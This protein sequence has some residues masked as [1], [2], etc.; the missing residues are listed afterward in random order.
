MSQLTTEVGNVTEGQS[1]SFDEYLERAWEIMISEPEAAVT[2]LKNA[3]TLVDPSDRMLSQLA[4]HEGWTFNF[5]GEYLQALKR[6][7][8]AQAL[9]EQ[10][11]SAEDTWR[12]HNGMG[13]AYQGM[14]QYGEALFHYGE[15]LAICQSIGEING[16]FAAQLNLATLHYDI[17][18][19]DTSEEL[20]N[21]ALGVDTTS[22]TA[23]NLGEAALLQ[24]NLHITHSRFQDALLGC[25]AALEY[26]RQLNFGHLEIQALIAVARCQRL[27]N[28]MVE[29]ETTLVVTIDHPEFD[30][31]GVTGLYAYIEL[32]K[33][34]ASNGHFSRA[35][36][37][38]RQGLRRE[39]L[40]EFSLIQQRA[41]ETLAV[42]LER[43]RKYRAAHTVLRLALDLE[44][45]LHQRDV[46]RQIE[47]RQYET[48]MKDERLARQ[49]AQHEN[50]Q[51][52]VVQSRLQLINELSRQLA[53]S[54]RI[55]DIGLKLYDIVKERL[56]VHF[57]S[58]ALNR[59]DVDAVEYV[60]A[61]DNGIRL[62]R[63]SIPYCFEQSPAVKAIRGAEPVLI[64]GND[65]RLC[66][67]RLGDERIVPQSQ[68][69][70]P[71][72]HNQIVIG[73]VSLQSAVPERFGDEEIELLRSLAPFIAIT[74]SN[75]LS[76]QQLYE[77]NSALSHEKTQIEAA[78][79][80]IE[81]MANH[82]T[83]T[84]LPNRRLL[85]NFV[86]QRVALATES[87]RSF[88]LVYI[89][90]DGF[91][92]VND[93][94]GHRVGDSVLTALANRLSDALRKTDFAARVGGDEFVI[95]IDDFENEPA[96]HAFISRMLSVIEKPVITDNEQVA[97]SA[98][99]GVA[100]YGTHGK[101]LDTLMHHAD[102]A[103]Y[104]IKRSGKGGIAYA[105]LQP[106]VLF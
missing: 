19:L 28:R 16:L 71:L 38:L 84:G 99:I 21:E 89:D 67:L 36:R 93:R 54:L 20:L 88:Y 14:G 26:S 32:A 106:R 55:E 1:I 77:V 53:S 94:H 37:I 98:S 78:Q 65:V 60:M 9:A 22:V 46:R 40:P 42:C 68:L 69:F 85:A 82:D 39:G 25:R 44:R 13:I 29:A 31:E 18:D 43:A 76:H 101:D 90:L 30:K 91:K 5:M 63:F 72:V 51:L 47:L 11:K 92:P 62:P 24:A 52:K 17:D 15:S 33:V 3:R 6:F 59:P 74:L 97:V 104:G 10:L 45:K 58:L 95:I 61:I 70:I 86:E 50:R 80:R 100:R 83:L 103:M 102:Q 79:Q 64:A 12:I 73:M 105:E 48:K 34:L 7:S 35:V 49:I 96:I 23:E 8:E 56:D 87:Q 4:F 81:H 27:Q 2:L 57:V 75:A 41:L 66:S